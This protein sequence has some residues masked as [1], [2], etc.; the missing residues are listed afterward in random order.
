MNN[1][2]NERILKL[3]STNYVKSI[4]NDLEFLVIKYNRLVNTKN[5]IES[6][7]PC[8]L[9]KKKYSVW[10]NKISNLDSQINN[11]VLDIEKCIK[12]IEEIKK[13]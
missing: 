6:N 3:L 2:L 13:I 10:K 7:K 4:N 12:D 9:F 1:V 11:T 5:M 8:S